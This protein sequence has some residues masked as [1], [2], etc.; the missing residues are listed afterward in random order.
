MF[1][2]TGCDGKEWKQAA[3]EQPERELVLFPGAVVSCWDDVGWP[4]LWGNSGESPPAE[5]HGYLGEKGLLFVK[6]AL[7]FHT[8]EV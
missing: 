5:I 8:H 6:S 2:L 7:D 3:E 1:A 4:L